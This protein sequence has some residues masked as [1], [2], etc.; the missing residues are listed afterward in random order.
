MPGKRARKAPAQD[1]EEQELQALSNEELR[2]EL[3]VVGKNPGP[4]DSSNR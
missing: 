1:K 4:I 3:I 2:K